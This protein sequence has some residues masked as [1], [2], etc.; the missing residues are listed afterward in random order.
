LHRELSIQAA[1]TG[2]SLNRLIN[3]RLHKILGR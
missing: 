1:E 3:S 2:V